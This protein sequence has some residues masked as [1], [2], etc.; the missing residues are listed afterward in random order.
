[1]NWIDEPIYLRKWITMWRIEILLVY[2]TCVWIRIV[3][4]CV[5]VCLLVWPRAAC[6]WISLYLLDQRFILIVACVY[7]F[8]EIKMPHLLLCVCY[9]IRNEERKSSK[10]TNK[11]KRIILSIEL[12]FGHDANY[13]DIA[14]QMELFLCLCLNYAFD[15]KIE[16]EISIKPQ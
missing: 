16:M 12:N 1:M 8:S 6:I 14:N 15:T 3:Y 2:I 9:S 13:V 4:V 11:Y 10:C 5:S 7:Q